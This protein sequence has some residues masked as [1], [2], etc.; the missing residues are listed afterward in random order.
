MHTALDLSSLLLVVLGG[1]AALRF[2]RRLD[3]WSRRRDLQLIVLAAP[4]VSL[5]L[6][7]G[8]IYHFAGRACVLGTP[9]WDSAAALALPLAMGV[10]AL[11]ALGLALVRL[12][13]VGRFVACRGTQAGPG[14]QA[15]A[16]RIAERL[17]APRPR[18]LVCSD[19]RPLALTC[20]LWRPTLLLSVWLLQRLDRRE[21]EAVLAHE[22]AH[23]A[24]RDYPVTWLATLLRD[25]FFYLPTSWMAHRQLQRDKEL[26]CDDLAIHT[27]KRPLALAS[28]LSKVWRQALGGPTLRTAQSLAGASALIEA[29]IERLLA[30]SRPGIGR[31]SSR[32]RP[33]ARP[34]CIALGIGAAALLGLVTVEVANAALVLAPMGCGPAAMLGKL[35]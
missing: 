20:G 31:E 23:A 15:L 18:V 33:D 3:G 28:A 2:S 5:A 22:L 26:A 24:R 29:R 12:A 7:I 35:M 10:V 11:G 14:L 6:G 30:P 25:A 32:A 1:L 13:L 27:T 8:G 19:A 34:R 17:G 9:P 21:L 4:V 16:E